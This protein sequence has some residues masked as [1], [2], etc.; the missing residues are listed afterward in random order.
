MCILNMNKYE[1]KQSLLSDS[2]GG[3]INSMKKKNRSRNDVQNSNRNSYNSEL[4]KESK[5]FSQNLN[6]VFEYFDK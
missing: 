6:E 3:S 5:E 1:S 2:L 4:W